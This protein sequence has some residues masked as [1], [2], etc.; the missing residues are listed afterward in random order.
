MNENTNEH[1]QHRPYWKRLHHS[2][3]FWIFLLLMFI[4]IVY[5]I[6]TVDFAFTPHQ[7]MKQPPGNQRIL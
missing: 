3:V 2:F 6:M 1:N 7:E 4:A 5:F